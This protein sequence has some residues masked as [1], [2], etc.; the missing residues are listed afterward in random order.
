[1][2]QFVTSHTLRETFREK[3]YYYYY[4]EKYS[5]SYEGHGH[6]I[7]KISLTRANQHIIIVW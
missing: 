6:K 1:M 5:E 2:T 4:Y 7:Q 3:H